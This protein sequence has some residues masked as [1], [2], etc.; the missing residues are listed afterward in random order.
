MPNRTHQSTAV[1][2][3]HPYLII[4]LP[5][6]TIEIEYHRESHEHGAVFVHHSTIN[7]AQA[8]DDHVPSDNAR[9]RP[10]AR[11]AESNVAGYGPS[12]ARYLKRREPS[13]RNVRDVAAQC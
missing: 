7:G 9:Q 6:I 10:S 12:V 4:S 3:K 8:G 1:L 2:Q 13:R 5:F 11:H